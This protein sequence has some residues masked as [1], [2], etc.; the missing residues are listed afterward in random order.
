MELTLFVDHACNLRCTYCYNGEKLERAMSGE[1][2]RRAVALALATRPRHLDVSFFGGEPL[3]RLDFLRESVEHVEREIASLP[4]PR[5]SLRF[6]LNTNGTLIDDEAIEL[7]TG[8]RFTVFVSVDGPADVHDRY[9]LNVVGA[10]S[11][12]RTL[13]G[14][15][16]LRAARI[17]FQIMVVYGAATAGRLGD[18]LT[19]LL[20]LGAEKILLNANYR[21]DWSEASIESLRGG[22]AAAARVWA[23]RVRD[24][25]VVPVEPFHTKILSH[26]KGGT[27]C[28]S[29][30]VLGNGELTVTPRGR[31]YPCPQMVGED[32]SDEHVIGDLDAGV[33]FA[34]AAELRAQKERNLET[35]ASCE[36]LERCQ[37]QCGCRH[38][39]AGGELGKITAVLCE[40]EA[41][42]IE[43]A[44][45]VAEALVEERVPA[46]VDYYYRRP[47]RPAPGAALVQL[48][49]RSS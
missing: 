8:R 37:N 14:V 40:L 48:S 45:R 12:A 15:R 6:I 24:G 3:I 21:D 20:P 13:A 49:R 18:A 16:R 2:M 47:W 19:E 29:R 41:A 4:A 34:R 31:L 27:P 1:T 10:G 35:C 9:R 7:L 32:D 38:V 46:F 22:L 28:G 36:L 26:L 17:P 42:S 23:D 39:A 5:P 43:A 25:A 30:C 44:D 33:D 11:H